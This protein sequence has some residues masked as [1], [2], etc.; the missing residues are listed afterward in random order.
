M[1]GECS[2]LPGTM[3]LS[4]R[5]FP[6]LSGLREESRARRTTPAWPDPAIRNSRVAEKY[7]L[8]N[9]AMSHRVGSVVDVGQ[10]QDVKEIRPAEAWVFRS[11]PDAW[12]FGGGGVY[13]VEGPRSVMHTGEV[14]PDLA[15]HNARSAPARGPASLLTTQHWSISGRARQASSLLCCLLLLAETDFYSLGND[16]RPSRATAKHRTA[17][18]KC[19]W[20]SRFPGPLVQGSVDRG[21]WHGCPPHIRQRAKTGKMRDLSSLVSTYRGRL[22]ALD[23]CYNLGAHVQKEIKQLSLQHIDAHLEDLLTEVK[24]KSGRT[25]EQITPKI[26]PDAGTQMVEAH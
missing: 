4:G 26:K 12:I 19:I 16:Y 21:A 14:I 18:R 2:G 6:S 22:L 9:I 13:G 17:V 23:M 15:D 25:F 24:T 20:R 3:G 10:C 1:L 8:V 7:S 11:L 5:T